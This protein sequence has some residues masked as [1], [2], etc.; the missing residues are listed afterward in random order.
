MKITFMSQFEAESLAGQKSHGMIS[1]TNP[2][3][4]PADINP[5]FG[6]VLRLG[7]HDIEAREEDDR[8]KAISHDQANQIVSFFRHAPSYGI[9]AIT[10]HCWAGISRS[11]A[12]A[13]IGCLIHGADIP[14]NTEGAN[15]T[16]LRRCWLAWLRQS[17]LKA[18]WHWKNALVRSP[19]R[20]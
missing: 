4:P 11:T 6:G 16:V 13:I 3:C 7:F 9:S 17:P 15:K 18:C 19:R 10:V 1:I 2:T 8:F 5:G 20:R 12:V 14:K